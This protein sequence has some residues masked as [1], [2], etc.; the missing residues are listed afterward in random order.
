MNANER[1][2]YML[3]TGKFADLRLQILNRIIGQHSR[4]FLSNFLKRG[5]CIAEIGCGTGNMLG[6]LSQKVGS[7]GKVYA[8]DSNR[9]QL[10]VAA[11]KIKN[12][13]IQN[14]KLVLD[15]AHNLDKLKPDFD[16]VY[17][18]L[19]LLHLKNPLLALQKMKSLLKKNRYMI[20]EEVSM[21]TAFCYPHSEHYLKS[22]SL[23]KQLA[24]IKGLDFDIG[25][26]LNDLML[27]IQMKLVDSR[28]VQPVLSDSVERKMLWLAMYESEYHFI[29]HKL[30]SSSEIEFLSS[31]LKEISR[32]K[33]YT[34]TLPLFTQI[35]GSTKSD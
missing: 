9:E 24:E 10:R 8:V 13:R 6:W 30:S 14:V 12:L 29:N 27:S 18:R 1:N 11:E 35:C 33:K 3:A 21:S 31:K 2:E 23:F 20:C 7:K 25:S 34:V 32:D 4:K 28:C 5:M 15:D 16:L 22:R 17:S 26:K 19:L